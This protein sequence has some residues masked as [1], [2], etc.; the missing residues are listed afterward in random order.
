M[1]RAVICY[2]FVCFAFLNSLHAQDEVRLTGAITE[3]R[4]GDA[5]P[6]ASISI[7]GTKKGTI[8]N[9]DG[10]YVL[11]LEPNKRLRLRITAVGFEPDTVEVTISQDTKKDLSL[12]ATPVKSNEIVIRGDASRVEA[13]R[14]MR[15]V[16]RRK[17]EWR[18]KLFDYK[19]EAY[20]RWNVKTISGRDTMIRSIVESTAEGYWNK[21]KG[22]FE[23]ITG[24]KQTANFPAQANVFSVGTIMNFYDDRIDFDEY[25]LVSPVADDAFDS[26]DYDLIGTTKVNGEPVWQIELFPGTLSTAFDGSLWIA[27]NDYTIAFLELEPS[28]AVKLGPLSELRMQQTF[29]LYQDSFWMPIDLRTFIEI[30]LAVPLV[31]IF[32]IELLSLIKNYTINSGLPDSLFAGKRNIALASAD[33]VDSAAWNKNRA[34]PLA[35]D[36]EKAYERIDSNIRTEKEAPEVNIFSLGT[37][38]S[39]VKIPRYNTVEGWRFGLGRDIKPFDSWPFTLSGE[40]A[41]GLR[42]EQWKYSVGLRQGIVFS[43][44][45]SNV[46]SASLDGDFKGEYKD[47][48]DVKVW[49]V[50]AYSN[51]ITAR[52]NLYSSIENTITSL[53]YNEDYS[54]FY[55]QK[56]FRAGFDITPWER[57]GNMTSI[58]YIETELADASENPHLLIYDTNGFDDDRFNYEK[59]YSALE[60]SANYDVEIDGLSIGTNATI[61]TTSKYIG[62]SYTFTTGDFSLSLSKR[63]GGWGVMEITGRY[64]TTFA[65]ELPRWNSFYFET[66]NKFFSKFNNFRGLY[67]FEFMG[68]EVASI[69]LEH[70]FYDLPTRLVGL[71]FMEPLNLQWRIHGGIAVSNTNRMGSA[72]V[73]TTNDRPYGEIG[74]GVGNILNIINLDATWRLNHKRETNFFPSVALQFSF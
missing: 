74:F 57:S 20:S 22:F 42:D 54:E 66:R 2:L 71:D 10:R 17:K 68:D 5:I 72:D 38:L 52:G 1:L 23:R 44:K 65:G 19:C 7:I 61:S 73:P 37:L 4:T 46:F 6:R 58:R 36:E 56:G 51:N 24:R 62:S 45:K 67:P 63:L 14:I 12:S 47:V 49:L 70:N 29:D 11:S 31:P 41:Y 27:Q 39:L 40:V 13:R 33:S 48:Q 8:A 34:I 53:A 25:D 26:Y 15:E 18:D 59:D 32:R 28:K 43:T 16:I 3:K 60:V 35:S 30:K 64:G 69:Y 21:E 9:K 55:Y 50:A